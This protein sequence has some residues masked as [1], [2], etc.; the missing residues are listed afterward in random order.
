M[1]TSQTDL[2]QDFTLV[3]RTFEQLGQRLTEVA[4]QVRTSWC[5]P[6]RA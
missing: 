3:T 4:E 5:F 1:E 6:Q 2:L